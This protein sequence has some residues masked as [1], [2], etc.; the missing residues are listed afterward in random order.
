[1]QKDHDLA[2]DLLLGPGSDDALGAARADAVDFAQALRRTLDDIENLVAE[3]LNKP[4]GIDRPDA[5][6]HAGGQVL[7]HTLDRSRL[8]R[9]QELRP[10]LQPMRAVILPAP[11]RR[12]PFAG[13][14]RGRMTKDGYQVLLS[15]HFH[16]E[17]AKTVLLVVKGHPLDKAGENLLFVRRRHQPLSRHA[18]ERNI[19]GGSREVSP[20]G[21]ATPA[22][23][24]RIGRGRS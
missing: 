6:D 7:L 1:M 4:F 19:P 10:E 18:N 2:H 5:A 8:C 15:A 24:P 17:H 9:F 23:P 13:R 16:A 11:A 14:D 22:S 3:R 21:S 12:H 20:V